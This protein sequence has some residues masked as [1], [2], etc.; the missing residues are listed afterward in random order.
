MVKLHELTTSMGLKLKPQKCRSLSIKSGKSE[1]VVFSLGDDGISSILHD[2]YH[3]FLGGLYTFYFSA[4]SVAT[5]IKDRVG[6]QLRYLDS[7]LVR[8]EYKVRIYSEY[9]LGSWR[10]ILSIHDLS[11]SQISD[12]ENLTHSYLKR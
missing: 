3:K 9:L 4:S 7:S 11:K 1:E 2:K 5:V 8:N 12:L 10:F 6:D